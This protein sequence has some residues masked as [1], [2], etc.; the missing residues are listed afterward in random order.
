MI[1]EVQLVESHV[2]ASG[3]V[4]AFTQCWSSRPSFRAPFLNGRTSLLSRELPCAAHRVYTYHRTRCAVPKLGFC[5]RRGLASWA[6]REGAEGPMSEYNSRGM[7]S[8]FRVF[9]AAGFLG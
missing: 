7:P 9:G 6:A 5:F 4:D 3:S 2:P 8:G 1:P